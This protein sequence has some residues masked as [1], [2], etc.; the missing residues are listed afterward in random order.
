M[1]HQSAWRAWILVASYVF[2]AWW[3]WRFVFLLACS[4]VGNHLAAAAIGRATGV[5]ARKALLAVAVTFNLGLLAYFKYA[6][7]LVSS[8]E[9]A[10]S[11]VGLPSSH[12]VLSVTLP[13]GISFF[14]FM[15]LSYVIDVYR[16]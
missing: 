6:G 2:Y 3:D 9:N 16:G 1:R 13:I 8:V 10:L 11:R 7:F 4:T 14:T 5:R 12:W 15:A